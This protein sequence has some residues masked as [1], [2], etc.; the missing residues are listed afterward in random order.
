MLVVRDENDKVVHD[1]NGN[2][3]VHK[4]AKN[5]PKATWRA[6]LR[7]MT[8]NGED[9]L[10]AIWNI[11]QGVPFSA[12]HKGQELEPQVPTAEV[13]LRALEYLATMN[14][15]KAPAASEVMQ[16]EVQAEEMARLSAM[17]EAQLREIA[18]PLLQKGTD[19]A[20][21]TE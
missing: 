1:K 14:F 2:A 11:G 13:R 8:N 10:T 4:V 19:D 12:T 18:A 5:A 21:I 6:F 17:S 20:D 7:E 9:L 16:A 3:V 15:G